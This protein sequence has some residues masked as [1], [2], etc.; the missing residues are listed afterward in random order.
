MSRRIM[1]IDNDK[2]GE[3]FLKA[4]DN[5]EEVYATDAKQDSEIKTKATQ[6]DF[7]TL[8]ARVDNL[9][10]TPAGSTEGNAEL[11]DIRVGADG[12]VYPTAGDAVREQVSSLEE[13]DENLVQMMSSELSSLFSKV[14][15]PYEPKDL[16]SGAEW[17]AGVRQAN[18]TKVELGSWECTPLLE[19]V[20]G[21]SYELSQTYA[22]T[23]YRLY[24]QDGTNG[25]LFQEF[26]DKHITKNV[27]IPD[28]KYYIAFSCDRSASF[29]KVTYFNQ[30]EPS[31]KDKLELRPNL[32][33][34]SIKVIK[35][36]T[37][38][39]VY[40]RSNTNKYLCTILDNHGTNNLFDFYKLG[41]CLADSLAECTA[42]STTL[43]IIIN[44]DIHSPFAIEATTN[45]DGDNQL[46][47]FTGGNHGY[48]GNTGGGSTARELSK[49]IKLDNRT[50]DNDGEYYGNSL[51]IAWVNGVQAWNTKKADGSGREV[52]RE[53][54]ILRFDGIAW[55]CN[56]DLEFLEECKVKTVYGYQMKFTKD[57][58]TEI[59]YLGGEDRTCHKATESSSSRNKNPNGILVR[60][61]TAGI[62]I[63]LELDTSYDCGD[64][65][66]FKNNDAKYGAFSP[67]TDKSYLYLIDSLTAE[68]QAHYRYRGYYT[69]SL[70]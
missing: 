14:D 40:S 19:V 15:T 47:S 8:K 24:D 25:E 30:L 45:A 43:S 32:L 52:L 3:L 29:N 26:D 50:L 12:K 21:M 59:Y 55:T 35:S 9:T 6:A 16:L 4:N 1:D 61:L 27:V 54:Q 2:V 22:H 37:S 38:L 10:Q 31:S 23:Q 64:R 36:G 65:R 58:S 69:I 46:S 5:F 34:P 67:A 53:H 44:T 51:E 11:L 49:L 13:A 63:N 62:S 20:P 66:F 57:E 41:Y 33:I 39:A 28:D 56:S 7:N 60:D 17:S 18:G 68:T 42:E 70:I 48:D